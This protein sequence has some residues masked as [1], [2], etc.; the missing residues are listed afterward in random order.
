ME[1]TFI[2]PLSC[3]VICFSLRFL[4]KVPF[5]QL[6][7]ILLCSL[8]QIIYDLPN[9]FYL[10][11]IHVFLFSV[12]SFLPFHHCQLLQS[13]TNFCPLLLLG[14]KIYYLLFNLS[15]IYFYQFKKKSNFLSMSLFF[16]GSYLTSHPLRH[17]ICFVLCE[18]T[19]L[20]NMLRCTTCSLFYV[21]D[22][23]MKLINHL[24]VYSLFHVTQDS[25]NQLVDSSLQCPFFIVWQLH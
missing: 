24:F 22:T 19:S 4:Q 10:P 9:F 13:C 2:R 18:E 7:L 17:N 20:Q 11:L 21:D 23:K 14:K 5:D 16:L 8:V 6:F 15:K 25:G 3:R 12:V 1:I